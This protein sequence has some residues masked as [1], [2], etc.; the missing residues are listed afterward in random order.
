M[1]ILWG[2]GR[3]VKKIKLRAASGACKSIERLVQIF[4]HIVTETRDPKG[5][6]QRKIDFDALRQELIESLVEGPQE[7]YHLNW[8]GKAQAH[9]KANEE[10]D[11]A[12]RPCRGESLNFDTTQNVFVEGDNLKVLKLLKSSYLG[13]V[14][15]IYIDPPY[16]TGRDFIYRDKFAQKS[17]DYQVHSGQK[18][19]GGEKLVAN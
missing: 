8:P 11:G 4:P 1:T 14:K 17:S 18:N 2:V 10:V 7:R 6:V 12:L 16:N 19:Q 5:R 9:L 3:G 13:K 15:M